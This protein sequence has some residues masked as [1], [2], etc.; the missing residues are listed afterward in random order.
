MDG[1]TPNDR[2]RPA[3]TRGQIVIIDPEHAGDIDG[4]TRVAYDGTPLPVT[5]DELQHA[6]ITT[7]DIDRGAYPHFLLKEISESPDS[8][9]KT[10]RGRI[11]Q[12]DGRLV[13][14]VG[15]ESLPDELRVGLRSGEI[16]RVIVIGQGTAAVAGQSVA[17]ALERVTLVV[18]ISQSGTTTDT[19]RTVDLVRQHGA[20]VVSIVNRRNSDLVDK[21]DGVL[22]TSDGRDAEM[23]VASTKAFYA[24]IAAGWLLALGIAQETGGVDPAEAHDVLTALRVLPDAMRQ[25]VEQRD[26][27]A[28]VAQ[29]QALTRRYWAVVG[30]GANVVAARE[31]RIKLSELCYKAI[32]CDSTED[33]KHIDLS[34]EPMTL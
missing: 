5:G 9:R 17:A 7:R 33:K 27:I 11:T 13:A 24:Q 18:A 10:L 25:V 34:S 20:R 12:R 8:F 29:R 30:N 22:F 31:L 21:S 1:E 6:Q 28:A 14:D 15:S 4:I 3:A 2:A 23:S 26:A 19:N 16:Q 32:A